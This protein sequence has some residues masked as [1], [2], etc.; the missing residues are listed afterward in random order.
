GNALCNRLGCIENYLKALDGQNASTATDNFWTENDGAV[1]TLWKE[2]SEEM[3]KNGTQDQTECEGLQNP[4]AVAA[5]KYLHAGLKQLYTASSSTTTSSAPAGAD[6]LKNN[7]SFRQ[8]MGCF[9]LHAY[10]KHMKEKATCLIDDGIQKAFTLGEELSK[11]GGK[12]SNC[13]NGQ[14]IP[15]KWEEEKFGECQIKTKD[16]GDQE[17]VEK[18]L[19]GIIEED[20]DDHIKTM[21]K[22]INEVTQL[23]DQVKCVTKRWMSHNGNTNNWGKVWEQVPEQLKA[24]AEATKEEKRKEVETMKFCSGLNE[25]GGKDACILIAAG[26]K[27]LY[28]IKE[29]KANGNDPVTASFQRTMQCVLLNAIADKLESNDFPCKDEKKV[30]DGINKAFGESEKIMEKG[31]GCQNNDKCFKCP[32][33]TI[34][35][36]CKIKTNDSKERPLKN[37]IDLRLKEDN[38]AN[39]S[40]LSK[41]SL[42]KTICKPCTGDENKDFCKQF[43]CVAQK[44]KKNR[45]KPNYDDL[46]VDSP[47]LLT[48][49]LGGMNNGTKGPAAVNEYCKDNNG[50]EWGTD[51]HG[52]AN[53]IACE[54]VAGGLQYISKIQQ[55]YSTKD[56]NNP[57]DNQEFKQFV[58]CLLLKGV[59][60][61]MKNESIICNID[62][63]IKAAFLKAD[64][65]KDDHCQNGR[66]CIVCK[67]TDEDYDKLGSCTVDRANVNVKEKL[68]KLIT[69]DKKTEVNKTLES[70]TKAGGNSGTLC[71][72]LQ[73]LSSKVEA[74]KLQGQSNTSASTFWTEDGDVG[75]L[76]KELAK[77]MKDKGTQNQQ[78]CSTVD[79]NRQPTDPEKRACNHLT[80]GFNKLKEIPSNAT[81]SYP[82][83]KDNPLLRQTVGCFL[84]KEYA[85]K[86]QGQSTC[87]ITSGLKK[88]FDTASNG[89]DGIQC[90]WEDNYDDCNITSTGNTQTP[91]TNKLEHVQDKIKTAAEDNL[92]KI[93]HMDKLCD[94][95][96]CAA[97]NWFKSKLSPTTT[98]VGSSGTPATPTKTWCDFWENEGVKPKLKTMFEKISSEGTGGTIY[99]KYFGDGNE[100]SVERKACNHII[101]GLKHINSITGGNNGDSQK[102]AKQL[103]ERTVACIALNMYADEIVKRSKDKCPIDES[104]IQSMFDFW[105]RTNKPP[106][107]PPCNGANTNDCFKCT[108][109]ADFSSCN[110]LVDKEL[111]G[112]PKSGPST[113]CNDN[114]NNTNKNVSKK[115]D[116][117][118]KGESKMEETLNKINE[119][120]TFCSELQCAARKWNFTENNKGTAPSW[121]DIDKDAKDELTKLIEDMMQ[122]SKQKDVDKYCKDK[123]NEW[124]KLGHKQSKTNKAACLLFASGL[125]HIY[126]RA[127]GQKKDRFKGPSFEQTMGCLFLK[128]YS[129]QLQ[130][131][132]NEKKKGHSWVHPLCD[133]DKGIKHAFDKSKNIM[134]ETSPCNNGNNSCFECTQKE[135]YYKCK[136]GDDDIGSKS[137]ELFKDEAKQTHLQQT[138]EN[139]V[140]PILLTDLL[141]P[142]LPLAPV[143][144]GL[145]AMAYYLWKYFGPLGKGG[146]RFRRSPGEIPGPSVQEQVLD[147]VEEAGPHEYQLVK[148]RKRR[149]SPT[150]TKRSGRTIIEIHFEVL[151]ECQKGDTQSN[152]KDFLELL[153]QEFMGSEFME[154]EQVPKE[155]VLMEGVPMESIPLEQVPMERVPSLGS[156]FMV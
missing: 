10:A 99:C 140:C 40:S 111:I 93:N 72:R 49:P 9:L 76:W 73:C 33:F 130:T 116:D 5:C 31:N 55:S 50:K 87:V 11:S 142:F 4:S 32:R 148:E 138:L 8:T 129:K 151:D 118:L 112:T 101:A 89:S 71:Q 80:A 106:S 81:S 70:I 150:R 147:H 75:K 94:Y 34:S 38:L 125:K 39:N 123:E 23:C 96:K 62:E 144:I 152:Q 66:P 59:V 16:N 110:L 92:K 35:D 149:S 12:G 143:S 113:T 127:N 153:V 77:E 56:D 53:R 136:I 154:E 104:K 74:L 132:A 1:A 3:E 64:K 68:E 65:I 86:M 91:V 45:G 21:A 14:C 69:M 52:T 58:S 29:D 20:K 17:N 139:T 126:G 42:I 13:T 117:L 121:S 37:E 60:Q 63:G 102:E 83:L 79:S 7:P 78:E 120:D 41:S 24:L 48:G 156:G 6:V 36:D 95:I 155:E 131:M 128:E 141:T 43:E 109:H 30:K 22:K 122:P 57:Y 67:W 100:R 98:G 15:C 88:A 146:P 47:W 54:L 107:S 134:E 61:K 90:K 103:F 25:K 82:I 97:P 133:I 137:N 114:D 124:Y 145:S 135:D 51:A 84:L 115:I 18:K 2:L 85:K 108:R 19:K 46:I 105:N 26:L 28:D 44:W 27:N 119:M